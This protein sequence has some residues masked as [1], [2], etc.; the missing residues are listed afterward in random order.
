VHEPASIIARANLVHFTGLAG[1]AVAA[2]DQ[3]AA[4]LLVRVQVSGVGHPETLTDRDN[5]AYWSGRAEKSGEANAE[6]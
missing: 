3:L 1:D 2:R 6:N 5:P 4:L